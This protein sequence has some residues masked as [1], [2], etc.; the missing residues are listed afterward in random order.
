MQVLNHRLH[1]LIRTIK[2]FCSC[3]LNFSAHFAFLFFKLYP[4]NLEAYA[5]LAGLV[6]DL[7]A[8]YK[9]GS[10]SLFDTVNCFHKM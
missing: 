5:G 9:Y 4:T 6:T 2:Y 10:W 7:F 3:P 8:G 1:V